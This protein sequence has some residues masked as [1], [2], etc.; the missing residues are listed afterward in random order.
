MTI[1]TNME[2]MTELETNSSNHHGNTYKIDII[3]ISD[4]SSMNI[5]YR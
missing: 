4:C 3:N 2:E 5:R 1:L